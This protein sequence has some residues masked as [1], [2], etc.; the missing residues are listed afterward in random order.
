M[1]APGSEW[2]S[3][4]RRASARS[5]AS[6]ALVSAPVQKS[7]MDTP[8]AEQKLLSFVWKRAVARKLT[9]SLSGSFSGIL[10]AMVANNLEV[11]IGTEPSI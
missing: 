10:V 6:M 3:Y 8:R 4:L 9:C 11:N 1:F 5:I 2:C 7:L